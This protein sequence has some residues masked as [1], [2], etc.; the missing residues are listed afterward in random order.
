MELI[1]FIPNIHPIFVHFTVALLST[2]MGLFLLGFIISEPPWR[3]RFLT[4]AQ[5]NLW[6]GAGITV[7]TIG[8]G[9][10]EYYT[11]THDEPSH[12]AMTNHRNWAF[13]TASFFFVLAPWSVLTY[14]KKRKIKSSFITALLLATVMLM[15]TGWKG[16]ELVYR[17][18][19]G[20]TS[21]PKATEGGSSDSH[22]HSHGNEKIDAEGEDH[23][24]GGKEH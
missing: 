8:T 23:G 2:S 20:V 3:E 19:L 18:G 16:G 4:V 14:L 5:W 22:D 15:I 17:Y 7:I 1:E 11:V 9:L 21:L 24:D 10:Y 6:L 13:F 12:S